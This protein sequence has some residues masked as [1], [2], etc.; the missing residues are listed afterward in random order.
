M[1]SSGLQ[2]KS[3]IDT[4]TWKAILQ[5]AETVA[6]TAASG[7]GAAKV[8]I[9]PSAGTVTVTG[10]P[11]EVRRVAE[12][13]RAY[14]AISDQQVEI[15]T[16]VYKVQLNA[17]D[18]YGVTPQVLWKDAVG[19]H[20]W[21]LQGLSL[22]TVNTAGTTPGTMSASI[23]SSKTNQS[24]LNGSQIAV[25]ALSTLGKVAETY[26]YSEIAQNGHPAVLADGNSISYLYSVSNFTGTV[27]GQSSTLTPGTVN[28][29]LTSMVTPRIVDGDIHLSVS[30]SDGS[31]VS[32]TTASSG[33]N[34]IQT[35]N[36][37][38]IALLEDV[39]LHPGQALMLS[40]FQD[41][42]GSATNNGVGSAYNPV[43]GGG[44]D[45]TTKRSLL[46]IVITAKVLD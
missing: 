10:T 26:S 12:W 29:G 35:P 41:T 37:N 44:F 33:S 16:R 13:V 21:S 36:V 24:D 42:N 39:I 18:N 23:V 46:A 5:N 31:L 3:E 1:S 15:T 9:D 11:A 25:R 34:S 45:A 6:D 40:G 30:L 27:G 32:L 43:F 2:A 20:S 7:Q 22:P 19:V 17:E 28:T 14:N 4:D 38:T 8:S